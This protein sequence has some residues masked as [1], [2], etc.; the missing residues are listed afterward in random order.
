MV[1]LGLSVFQLQKEI[2][3]TSVMKKFGIS[4][5]AVGSIA[6]DVLHEVAKHITLEA[7]AHPIAACH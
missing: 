5:E 4:K 6:A 3:P 1:E 2:K 7:R